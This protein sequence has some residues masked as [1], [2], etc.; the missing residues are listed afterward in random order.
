VDN[1]PSSDVALVSASG[2]CLDLHIGLG[3]ADYQIGRT[4]CSAAGVSVSSF[5]LWSSTPKFGNSARSA[6]DA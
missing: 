4:A 2:K 1:D 3:T 6:S 5:L